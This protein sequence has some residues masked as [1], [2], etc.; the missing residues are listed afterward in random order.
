[1]D[2]G[3]GQ[4]VLF[5]KSSKE[6]F[7]SDKSVTPKA[8]RTGRRKTN[9]GAILSFVGI[10]FAASPILIAYATQVAA[11]G[12]LGI[13]SLPI[14]GVAAVIGLWHMIGGIRQTLKIGTPTESEDPVERTKVLKDKS[15]SIALLVPVLLITLP[16]ISFVAGSMVVG[17]YAGIITV[18]AFGATV[19]AAA[20]FSIKFAIQSKIKSLPIVIGILMAIALVV[21]FFEAQALYQ[22]F[23]W[24]SKIGTQNI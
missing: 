22:H 16:L 12:W 9:F 10:L 14:G 8:K 5:Q 19:P 24:Q 18:F 21:L 11:W 23:I 2:V 7:M 6:K 15:V 1:V 17:A 20:W 4:S 3:L 13:Y